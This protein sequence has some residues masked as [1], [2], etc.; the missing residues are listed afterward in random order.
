ML[1]FFEALINLT[2]DQVIL[3][4]FIAVGIIVIAASFPYDDKE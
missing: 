4:I 2:P 3:L 1:S